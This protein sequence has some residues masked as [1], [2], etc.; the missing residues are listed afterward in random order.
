MHDRWRF[1]SELRLREAGSSVSCI[2][3]GKSLRCS[4]RHIS[5][6]RSP[7]EMVCQTIG[8]SIHHFSL[9]R[10]CIRCCWKSHLWVGWRLP[11][12]S[13]QICDSCWAS[14]IKATL[15]FGKRNMRLLQ[16]VLIDFIP[17]EL[18]N[19]ITNSLCSWVGKRLLWLNEVVLL[20]VS[21]SESLKLI[22]AISSLFSW[23]KTLVFESVFLQSFHATIWVKTILKFVRQNKLSE[24]LVDIVCLLVLMCEISFEI[25]GIGRICTSLGVWDVRST[26]R[27][28]V[29]S[30]LIVLNQVDVVV[31]ISSS[32]ELVF[33]LFIGRQ[34]WVLCKRVQAK[35]IPLTFGSN[36]VSCTFMEFVVILELLCIFITCFLC[37]SIFVEITVS[38]G[39]KSWISLEWLQLTARLLGSCR[40]SRRI[41]IIS[42]KAVES[43]H[44]S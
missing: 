23:L 19:L 22:N 40:W 11:R 43:F 6:F 30:N 15:N 12:L 28:R 4:E 29:Y 10:E 38:N 37:K 32:W 36:W 13:R 9:W 33:I 16:E 17:L 44:L 18:V 24:I 2:V 5:Y 27:R 35:L 41:I 7:L 14:L 31:L 20:L 42:S 39:H 8:I 1:P 34:K 21:F 26:H 3:I 25:R